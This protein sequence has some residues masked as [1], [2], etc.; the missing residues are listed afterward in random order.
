MNE[1]ELIRQVFMPVA[2]A[3]ANPAVRL[4]PGDDGAIQRLPPGSELVFSLDTLVEGVHFP[5]DYSPRFLGWRGLAVAASDL[6]AMGA[7]PVCFTLGL[8]LPYSD[9]KWLKAFA[10]GLSDAAKQFG[11]ALAGG[12]TTRGPLTLSFQVHGTV[13]AG[14][15]ILRSG[16][17][18][19][20]LIGVSGMLGDACAALRWL[21]EPSPS[22]HART[23]LGRYHHPEPKLTLGQLLRGT[24]SAAVD[25]SD[26]LVA[27]LGHILA[28]SGVGAR[29]IEAAIPR[30]A[31]LMA[32]H[33]E[34]SLAMALNGGDDYEICFT[35]APDRWSSLEA[36]ANRGELTVIGE[37]TAEP[38]LWLSDGHQDRPVHSTG[39]D[40]FGA[41]E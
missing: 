9:D 5:A 32:L 36:A 1:F 30:S 19:G 17:H 33:G 25:I 31:A 7:D 15:A 13:P 40:H 14:T 39:Y 10:Q 8:T 27:D 20:D 2:V 3:T 37:V 24:A 28:A 23:L 35:V 26:G 34:E 18:T 22:H 38:G 6:A 21:D 41:D 29:L 12:D 16:A 11:L 4:G